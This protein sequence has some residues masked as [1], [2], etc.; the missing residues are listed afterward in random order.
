MPDLQFVYGLFSDGLVFGA[1][2]G[3]ISWLIGYAISFLTNLIKR[4]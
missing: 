3:A 4:S 2:L 1:G